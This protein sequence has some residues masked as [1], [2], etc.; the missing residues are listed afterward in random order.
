MQY[1]GDRVGFAVQRSLTTLC[2]LRIGQEYFT[3]TIGWLVFT[4]DY[5][6]H[7]V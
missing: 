2:A 5:V 6:S 3:A 4:S 7:L 1:R